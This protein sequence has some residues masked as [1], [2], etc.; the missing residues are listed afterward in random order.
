MRIVGS[1]AGSFTLSNTSVQ[2]VQANDLDPYLRENTF[3]EVAIEYDGIDNDAHKDIDSQHFV[4]RDNGRLFLDGA[5]TQLFKAHRVMVSS[6][7]NYFAGNK[8][9]KFPEG[10]YLITSSS[11]S[12]SV[13][14]HALLE[15]SYANP[16]FKAEATDEN[17]FEIEVEGNTK[18]VGPKEEST[19]TLDQRE[20]KPR[21]AQPVNVTPKIKAYNHGTVSTYGIL[22]GFVL[23]INTSNRDIQSR[24]KSYSWADSNGHINDMDI[25]RTDKFL[26]GRKST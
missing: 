23:P 19:L 18:I 12:G 3:I 16:Q 10:P 17:K 15:K 8:S 7:H 24:V 22:G 26:I 9:L 11:H 2:R 20:I 6:H 4:D 21:A 13:E 5:P 14:K 1:V 25:V